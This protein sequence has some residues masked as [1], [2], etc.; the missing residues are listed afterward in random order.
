MSKN[1]KDTNIIGDD[2]DEE[3]EDDD[4][5]EGLEEVNIDDDV[6]DEV[7][8][9][10]LPGDEEDNDE[11]HNED[12]EGELPLDDDDA[13]LE[14]EIEEINLSEQQTEVIDH[15]ETK[16]KFY[17]TPKITRNIL[18]IYEKTRVLGLREKQL[19]DGAQ[20]TIDTKDC[21]NERDIAI[22]ELREGK[23]PLMIV[24]PLPN[25]GKEYWKLQDLIDIN[26]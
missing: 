15:Y 23:I 2:D 11:E 16:L 6:D 3:L 26:H 4:L 1:L 10:G 12:G 21:N 18:T 8:V 24:R 17:N 25:G 9:D 19:I 5:D 13:I 22:K 20:S 7:D 14:D